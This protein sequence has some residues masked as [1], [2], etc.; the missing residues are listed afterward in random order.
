MD[1]ITFAKL[2]RWCFCN[3]NELLNKVFVINDIPHEWVGIG[4]IECELD[5][6]KEAV[7]VVEHGHK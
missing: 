5:P 2:R 1:E 4:M 7:K 3:S 6:K